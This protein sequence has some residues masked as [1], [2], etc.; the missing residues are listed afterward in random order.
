[1][2][3]NLFITVIAL[4]LSSFVFSQI[5][6]DTLWTKAIGGSADEAPAYYFESKTNTT[7]NGSGDIFMLTNTTSSD[8]YIN[9]T[10]GDQ[11]CWLVKLNSDGDTLWT[12]VFGG[13]NYDAATSIVAIE[14]GGCVAVGFTYSNDNDFTNNHQTDESKTDGFITKFNSDGEILWSKLYGGGD[15]QDDIGGIDEL[16]KVTQNAD[17]N[18]YA[19]GRT[20]SINGDL[21]FDFT[22]FM[23]AWLLEVDILDGEIINSEKIAGKNHNEMNANSLLDIKQLPDE[24][25]YIAI[26]T[27]TY[28]MPD[29]LWL[30]KINN[31]ADT[32]WTKEFYGSDNDNY[33][34]GIAIDSEGNYI[35]S[36]WI[37]GGG[38]NI[39]TTYGNTDCWILK[40]N[41]EGEEIAQNTFGGSE[42]ETIYGIKED[43]AGGYYIYGQTRSTDYYAWQPHYGETDFWLV[44]FDTNLDSIF[45]YKVGGTLYEAIN[46]IAVSETGEFVYL[47][48]KTTSND[49]FIHGNNGEQDVWISK[50]E[51]ERPVNINENITEQI[52]CYPNP[53]S[54]FITIKNMKNQEINIY[55]ITGKSVFSKILKSENEQ[56]NLSK[57]SSGIYL[58]KSDSNQ[59]TK[60]LKQ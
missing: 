17:G 14:D 38:S 4:F 45:T 39:N 34:R 40:T 28:A 21:S 24:S 30:V 23:G 56:I 52:I 43:N 33:P 1:M 6:V 42:S 15:Q 32:V 37:T 60:I 16:L 58:L 47:T 46:D 22:K 10:I 13:T 7:I 49:N 35:I 27:Q 54:D 12:K 20:N 29:N 50:L 59:T 55:D 25:G 19:I 9:N 18:I 8:G 44:N 31:N 48:G 5:Q 51:I 11:D 36:S 2:K 41:N 53:T 57:L 3:K 26:G